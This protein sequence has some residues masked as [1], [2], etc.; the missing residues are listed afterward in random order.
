MRRLIV[1]FVLL[2]AAA[3][4]LEGQNSVYGVLG[5]GFPG[6]PVSPRARAMGGGLAA[7]DARSPLSPAPVAG[8][9][10]V[11]VTASTG[12]ALWEFTALDSTA[13]GLSQTRAPM[14]ILGGSVRGT[15][16]SFAL[17]YSTFAERTWNITTADSVVIRGASIGVTDEFK[18]D[19][20]VTDLRGALAYRL[21]PKFS[22]GAA[23]HVLGG[24]SRL[25][26]R[27][28]FSTSSYI[29][30]LD[31]DEISYSGM[32][33]SAGVVATLDPRFIVSVAVRNDGALESRSDSIVVGKLDLP[34]SY[35]GGLNVAPVPSLRLSTTVIRQHWSTMR[36]GLVAEGGATAFD[37]WDFG[38]GLEI[39]RVPILVGL[40]LLLGFRYAQLPFGPNEQQPRELGFSGGTS[41]VLSGGRVMF[42][43]AIE[44][45]LRDGGGAEERSWFLSFAF[46]VRP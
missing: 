24:S 45:I 10:R 38:A 14:G 43:A 30:L 26:T 2:C 19:G 21:S 6:R 35:V 22:V 18:S 33:I 8:F 11:M 27:R 17:S 31:Q 28:V 25:S 20:A 36:S 44:R 7:F 5:I 15:R 23:I 41:L 13:E 46:T 37:T 12:T 9:T 16:V 4:G 40:P 39:N 1:G 34:W 42:D 32:G 3:V 29:T